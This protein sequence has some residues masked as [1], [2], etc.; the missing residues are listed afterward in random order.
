MK[1]DLELNHQPFA[2]IFKY[3]LVGIL[4]FFAP[5]FAQAQSKTVTGMVSDVN[6]AGIPGVTVLVKGTK[7]S[8]IT[9]FDGKYE[10]KA[11]GENAVLVFSY[12]GFDNAEIA[13]GTKTQV[14]ATL[15][16]NVS[17][18][19]E[20][21]V[22]GYG[23]QKK[24]NLTGAVSTVSSKAIQNRP[25]TS[26]AT[27]LQGTVPGMN[28][29]RT[30]GQPGR[31]NLN[32]QI[33]GVTS[34]N[35]SVNPLLLIDGVATPLFNLQTINPLDVE[36]MSVLKDGAAAAIYGAQAAGGVI[37]VTTKKGK[38]GKTIFEYSTQLAVQKPLYLPKRMSLLDEANL[39][40][41]ARK[42][43]GTGAEYTPADLDN[44]KNGVEYI[45]D[46]ADPERYIFYDQKDFMQQV[47]KEQSIMKTHNLS[48]SGGTERT[49]YLF[50]VGYLDQ[51]G[52][53]KVGKDNFSRFNLR[54]N[55]GTD[56]TKHI[57]L[58]SNISYAVHDT[59]APAAGVNGGGALLY[60]LYKVRQRFPIF[61]PE[62][63]LNG[64]SGISGFNTYAY[65]AEGGYNKRTIDDL[66]GTFKMTIKDLAKGLK[67]TTIY[68]R[69]LRSEDSEVFSRT[70]ELWGRTKPLYVLN[71]PNGYVLDQDI[72]RTENFQF[73]TDYNLTIAENHEFTVLGGYQWEDYRFSN[74]NAGA[75][76]LK[77]NDVP[78]LNLGEATTKTNSQSIQTYANQ[79]YFGRFNYS[80]KDKYLVEATLRT[81]ESSRLAPG[82][83]IKTFPSASLGWNIHK[84]GWVSKNVPF[85]S[86]LKPR[87]SWGQLANALGQNIGNYDYLSQ[88]S[89]GSNLV[90]GGAEIRSSFF[91]QNSIPSSSLSWETVETF[92][93]GVDF[94]FF[95]NKL[96]GSF[97]YYTKE[98]KN[99]LTP[100]RLPGTF[101]VGTPRI[102]N[103]ILQ[104]WGWELA[105]NYRDKIGSDFNYGI[106]F[107]L[108]DNQNK[109]VNYAGVSVIGI[110]TNRLIE[111]YPL[112]TIWGYKTAPGYINTP[113]QL[114]TTPVY[115][116]LT[117]VGDIAYIDQNGDGKINQ[118]KGTIEDHGDL[119]QLGQDQQR[120]LFGINANANWKNLDF[121][122]FIQ[123]VGKRA[124]MPSSE[125]ITPFAETYI[126]P[127][128]IHAD[129]WTPENQNAAF[130][131][132][133][134]NGYHNF[135]PS[136]RW[137]LD[138]AYAR[139]KN[140]Q[141]GYS[142]SKSVLDK[143]F[144]SRVRFYLSAENI[145]TV[146]K[147]GVFKT[148]FDPEQRNGIYTDYPVSEIISF[149]VN[150][151]F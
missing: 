52:I 5:A 35:G 118:G 63:R 99:M 10:I 91:S 127:M 85:I 95:K 32:I 46:P 66:D 45:L 4:L 13:V 126:M 41:L 58:D 60:Q 115:S 1:K 114:A 98:N 26:L 121:T 39:S 11:S 89:T 106:G 139:L 77:S 69:K 100:L 116:T 81:D 37:L 6:K 62:G 8:T 40:N 14:N 112:A 134:L 96:T 102:N 120:Y 24:E 44:I 79:S 147:F 74:V 145:A 3:L 129:Y 104:S 151:T 73:L 42:N 142:L 136:D 38:E 93:Y 61:T 90:L 141:L 97:D 51:E 88:L 17:Q 75:T 80:Y 78:T 64:M 132:P 110:G 143:A 12:I 72:L 27:A 144:L 50:S 65:L 59:D 76:N 16:E 48:A 111:G 29:T 148:T 86:E 117:G 36:T 18:L 30:T 55:I 28:V 54:M 70:V 20:V 133:Y 92:N 34:A 53:F 31:E 87:V 9:N 57:R 107:N 135:I 82:L 150:L 103:G 124:I 22:V 119:V 122:V 49:N 130:P 83:R 131:R 101:G 56:L 84:E 25:V 7:T 21:I 67:F 140:I 43:R 125:M 149:G 113:E 15:K 2:F 108:S 19:S 68:G 23:T 47:V 137:V 71:N 109:L 105:V 146:S 123:G 128:A 94:G 33:R 138:A